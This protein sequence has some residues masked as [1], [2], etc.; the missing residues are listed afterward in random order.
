MGFYSSHVVP[1]LLHAAMRQEAFR[2]IRARVVGAAVGSVLEIGI[3]SGLNL[4][5]YG[6]AVP[7]V[8]GIDPSA[9]LLRRAREAAHHLE[10]PLRLVRG[11]AETL[12]FRSGAFDTVVTTWTFCT[13]SDPN[14][15]AAEIKRVLRRDG[16]L[17]FVEHGHAVDEPGICR[18]QDRLDPL[19]SRIAGG[20]HINR[21][22]DDVFR[23]AGFRLSALTMGHSLPGPLTHTFFYEGRAVPG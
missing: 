15:A 22:I 5:H 4:P 18:W 11:L 21:R 13:I 2:P 6:R 20:C 23:R 8:T 10:L 3:G 1:C 12:P 19:W 9:A 17:L 14:L 16:A 7:E